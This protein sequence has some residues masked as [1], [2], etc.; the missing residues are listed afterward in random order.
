MLFLFSFLI[1]FKKNGRWAMTKRWVQ[2]INLPENTVA[3]SISVT[4]EKQNKRFIIT[5]QTQFESPPLSSLDI[6]ISM[7]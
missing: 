3:T 5:G 4:V 6:S 2:S 7:K 1:S